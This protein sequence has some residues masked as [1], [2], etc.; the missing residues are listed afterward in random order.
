[1]YF[2]PKKQCLT[3][4]PV[5]YAADAQSQC[6]LAKETVAPFVTL[7]G[8]VLIILLVAVSRC[9]KPQTRIYNAFLALEGAYLVFFWIYMLVFLI[10]DY[11]KASATMIGIALINNYI[12]NL[13]WY[14]FYKER[15]LTQ[16]P[17]AV[18]GMTYGEY[19]NTYKCTQKTILIF[20]L[21]TTFQL[22]RMQYCLLFGA[23]QYNARFELTGKLVK[24]MNRYSLF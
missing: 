7:I 6:Y 20:S 21:L 15:V 8:T 18:G 23:D 2:A 14:N 5:N 10:K 24:R 22:F 13:I 12:I 9:W 1:M 19:K 4:C 11:H 17:N 16:Q 3:S